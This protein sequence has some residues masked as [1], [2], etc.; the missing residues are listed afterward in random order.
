[1]VGTVKYT[2]VNMFRR[3]NIEFVEDTLR[4]LVDSLDS[5]KKEI[6]KSNTQMA[7]YNSNHKVN[8]LETKD[9]IYTNVFE[10]AVTKR[11]YELNK[12][13]LING[14]KASV[15]RIK[16]LEDNAV[17]R[18]EVKFIWSVI[19]TVSAVFTYLFKTGGS[20]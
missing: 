9:E 7:E 10:K 8:L 6:H 20:T 5:I 16:E 2:G 19:L 15:V 17:F 12:L 18:R 1:M 11:E 4:H 14:I 13:E 3:Y